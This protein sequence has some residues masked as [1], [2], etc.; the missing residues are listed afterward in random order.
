MA[1]AIATGSSAWSRLVTVRR[2]L[3]CQKE[4]EDSSCRE[5]RPPAGQAGLRLR[6]AMDVYR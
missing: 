5:Q 4:K 1:D 6:K 2:G 3:Q